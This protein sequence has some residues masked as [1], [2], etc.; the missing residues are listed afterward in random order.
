MCHGKF[1]KGIPRHRPTISTS[2][3]MENEHDH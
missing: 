1:P 3:V 2:D